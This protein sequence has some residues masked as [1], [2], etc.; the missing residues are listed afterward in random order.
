M[1]QKR[2]KS[3]RRMARAIAREEANTA[4][5]YQTTIHGK[6]RVF[7]GWKPVE[8][9]ATEQPTLMETVQRGLSAA[10][11]WLKKMAGRE[12]PKPKSVPVEYV[13]DIQEV[14]CSTD[15]LAGGFRFYL[16]RLKRMFRNRSAFIRH[17]GG[18][19]VSQR[20]YQGM[21]RNQVQA[22]RASHLARLAAQAS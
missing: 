21:L 1:N 11:G 14:E 2:A 8:A 4:P 15:R 12:E 7:L 20:E 6:R 22:E 18:E 19:L 5:R 13:R 3:L 17:P 10:W 16:Q 9:D